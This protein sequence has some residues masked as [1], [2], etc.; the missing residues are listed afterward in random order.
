MR[1]SSLWNFAPLAVSSAATVL[2]LSMAADSMAAGHTG[3]GLAFLAAT[4]AFS[5]SSVKEIKSAIDDADES[6]KAEERRRSL[7]A[8]RR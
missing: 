2:N 6:Q 4:A 1:L 7:P 8:I 3:L 5:A